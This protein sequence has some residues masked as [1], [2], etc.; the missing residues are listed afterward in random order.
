MTCEVKC[1]SP[2]DSR[3]ITILLSQKETMGDAAS[4]GDPGIRDHRVVEH[5]ELLEDLIQRYKCCIKQLNDNG[6][7]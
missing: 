4:S 7:K 3:F 6:Q 5:K 2:C 1:R